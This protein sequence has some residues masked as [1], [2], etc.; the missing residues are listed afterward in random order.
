LIALIKKALVNQVRLFRDRLVV[1]RLAAR[2]TTC[3]LDPRALIKVGKGCEVR[4]GKGVAIGAFSAIIVES[5]N[6]TTAPENV[7]LQIGDRT[8]I[9]ELN[10]IRAAGTTTIGS[11]CLISQGVSIIGSNHSSALGM[12]MTEQA[13]RTDK[14]GVVI[15]DDVWIGTNSTILP[16]VTIGSGAIVAAGSVVTSDVAGN[17][18]VAGCPARLLKVRQ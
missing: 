3:R 16:G 15:G 13:S 5:D 9:G 8:Y 18:I 2:N 1:E 6:R 12:L 11:D 7:T 14:S 17:T 10:N 4:L